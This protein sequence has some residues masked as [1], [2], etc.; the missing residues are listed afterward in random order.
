[1][2]TMSTASRFPKIDVHHHIVPPQAAGMLDD[3]LQLSI[4]MLTSLSLTDLG[5]DLKGWHQPEWTLE[6]DQK[7][8][9]SVGI[10]TS[11][12]SF[13]TPGVVGIKDP[14]ESAR[15]ARSINDYC[16]ELRDKNP[17]S[18]GFFATLPSLEH[19]ELVLGEI[20]HALDELKADG[21]TLF[22]SYAWPDGYLGHSAFVPIWEELDRR[23][24]V[25][26]VHPIDNPGAKG[27]NE[28]LPMPAFDWPHETGRT[29]IDM[30]LH[31]RMQ[32]FPNVKIILSHGGGTLAALVE[33]S[34]L[35]ALPEF[36][37]F[38]SHD[39]IISQ[40]KA[41]YFDLALSG[42]SAMLPLILGFAAK[43][44][45]FYGSDWPHATTAFSQKNTT[46]IDDYPMDDATRE[47]IYFKSAYKLFPRLSR[48]E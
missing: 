16:A 4:D 1:M 17:Q 18:L 8:C 48:G 40:A 11:I 2:I 41:F 27:F 36:G 32:Q 46:F 35:I 20:Q 5:S 23:S 33:R 34:T 42:S 43:D 12:L 37:G 38:M 44:H 19:T 21:V 39:D 31:R 22:T 45:L 3:A 15:T 9:S 24:A 47:A 29:A 7:F 28:N 30:I 26:F 13:S 14:Q 6:S 25:V 10:K